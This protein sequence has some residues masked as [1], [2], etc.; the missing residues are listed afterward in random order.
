[1]KRLMSLL[2]FGCAVGCGGNQPA[3]PVAESQSSPRSAPVV[4]TGKPSTDEAISSIREY[5]STPVC[6]F[7]NIQVEKIS[8][9]VEAPKQAAGDDAWVCSVTMNC[10]NVIGCP[11]QNK[12]WLVLMSRDHGRVT[13]KDH[14]HNL[15]RLEQSPLGKQWFA[16]KGFPEPVVVH[17][18]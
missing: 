7:S 17:Q 15:E 8:D 10:N 9:P 18:D 6:G 16:Q 5:F 1:M 12:N 4:A 11:Q 14:Y 13:V 3:A 2:L